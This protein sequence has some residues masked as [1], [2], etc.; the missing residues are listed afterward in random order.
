MTTVLAAM[1]LANVISAAGASA[2]SPFAGCPVG[3]TSAGG[4]TIGAWQLMDEATLGAALLA[5]GVDPAN[6][7][8]ILARDDKNGDG[9]ICVMTQ[10]LPNDASGSEVWFVSHDNDAREK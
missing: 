8:P 5:A 7:A 10:L 2:A 9:R 3:P 4:S 6:A 1:S